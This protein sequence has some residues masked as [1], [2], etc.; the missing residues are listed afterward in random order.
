MIT[1][2]EWARVERAVSGIFGR[3]KLKVDGREVLLV[4]ERVSKNGLGVVIY[5]DG[6]WE[7]SWIGVAKDDCPEQ[8]YMCPHPRF[9]YPAKFRKELKKAGKRF[10]KKYG[11]GDPDEKVLIYYPYATSLTPIR[12]HYQKTFRSLELVEVIGAD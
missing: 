9:R 11:W 8:R 10:C 6:S 3:A 5:V 2:E 7:G 12:R 4:R 1:K